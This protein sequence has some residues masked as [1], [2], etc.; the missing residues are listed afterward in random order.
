MNVHLNPDNGWYRD[1]L[2]F[3][4]L[5]GLDLI[6]GVRSLAISKA[7]KEELLAQYGELINDS[8]AVFLAEYGGINVKTLET[9]RRDVREAEGAF[10][11]TKNTLLRNALETAGEPVPELLLKGQTSA[12][13]AMGEAPTLAKA[14]VD[15]A[16]DEDNFA[17]KGGNF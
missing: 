4:P 16:K 8:K 12:S 17:I 13:F 14:L 9:L 10:A 2:F 7:R 3:Q 6:G 1:F 5:D 15:F 11:V